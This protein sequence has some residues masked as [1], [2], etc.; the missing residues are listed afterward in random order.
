QRVHA[1][2]PGGLVI[3]DVDLRGRATGDATDEA[4]AA[5]FAREDALQ[6]FDLKAGPLVR[7]KLL[8]L[9]GDRHV[10]LLNIHHIVC[11]GWSID[12]LGREWAAL[13]E[14]YAAGKADPLP[15][16]KI[17]YRDYAA[18]QNRLLGSD[19]GRALGAYW[20]GVFAKP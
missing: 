19:E 4:V 20:H 9:T 11:D 8:R 17:Q 15:P 6:P 2:L 1:D 3:E 5:R 12:T 18:W 10:V 16:L 7:V 13:Y 14:A